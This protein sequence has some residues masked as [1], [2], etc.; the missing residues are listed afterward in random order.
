MTFTLLLPLL[1]LTPLQE[2]DPPQQA[3]EPVQSYWERVADDLAEKRSVRQV[4]ALSPR[5]EQLGERVRSTHVP[6]FS[7]EEEESLKALTEALQALTGIPILV[8]MAAEESVLDEGLTFSLNLTQPYNLSALLDLI[9]EMSGGCVAW[10]VREG[11]VLFT[12]P[13]RA[14]DPQIYLHLIADLTHVFEADDLAHLVM[15]NVSVESWERDG[16]TLDVTGP[17]LTVTHDRSVQIR[18]EDFLADLR[19]FTDSLKEAPDPTRR[20]WGASL[21]SDLERLESVRLAPSFANAPIGTV[22]AFLQELTGLH[23]VVSRAVAED[24]GEEETQVSLTLPQTDVRTILDLI[25]ELQPELAWSV[26]DG[27]VRIQTSD[28]CQPGLVLAFHDVRTIVSPAP[29]ECVLHS[30]F[31]RGD[32]V[33]E[34]LIMDGDYLDSLIRNSIAPESWDRNPQYYLRITDS[35]ILIVNQSPTAQEEICKLLGDLQA[36]ADIML[37]DD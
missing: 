3:P 15:E 1:L 4:L 37:A 26:A 35:G 12:T 24:L 34:D 22:A 18:I 10:T 30:D 25:V 14:L 23:F 19:A 31:E 2:P 27:I 28:E 16:V 32:E 29:P 7:V 36:I 13:E 21:Q 11:A 6:S 8:D 5:T 33:Y 9:C 17:F 20:P